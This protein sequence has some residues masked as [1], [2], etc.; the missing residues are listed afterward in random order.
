MEHGLKH[1]AFRALATRWIAGTL[2]TLALGAT[3]VALPG[4]NILGAAIVL[5]QG[6]PTTPAMHKLD[7]DRP[8]VVFVDDRA[9][10]LGRRTLRQS[11][12]Q[13]A[14]EALIKEADLKNVID[15]RASLAT[16]VGETAAE[17]LDI[18]SIGKRVGAEIVIYAVVDTFTLSQ[19][20]QTFVPQATF[21]VKVLDVTKEQ[22][23]IWPTER[24]GKAITAETTQRQGVRPT[25]ATE[26]LKAEQTLA[27]R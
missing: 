17:P 11:I 2:A 23:R 18:V 15:A 14:Q 22:P 21:R 8:T 24:E 27:E 4:C 20:G 13:S 16:V 19:D 7:K 9:N 10:V 5:V 6:P 26:V 25:N 12:A 3:A 1:R